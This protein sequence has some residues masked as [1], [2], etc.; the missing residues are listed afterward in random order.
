MWNKNIKRTYWFNF[1]CFMFHLLMLK[2]NWSNVMQHSVKIC[3][4]TAIVLI[5]YL[6]CVS[7]AIFSHNEKKSG[8]CCES[9]KILFQILLLFNLL[10][11]SFLFGLYLPHLIEKDGCIL[12]KVFQKWRSFAFATS[13][14]S[15]DKNNY[16]ITHTVSRSAIIFQTQKA[17]PMTVN[18]LLLVANCWWSNLLNHESES[19]SNMPVFNTVENG[20]C[21]WICRTTSIL[22]YASLIIPNLLRVLYFHL[23]VCNCFLQP[24]NNILAL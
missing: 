8:E 20:F 21:K 9:W 7:W 13:A 6:C 22:F 5:M 16:H 17:T 11:N 15:F 18:H 3:L 23:S 10:Q 1:H 24:F 2:H 19:V 12:R 4:K 14:P